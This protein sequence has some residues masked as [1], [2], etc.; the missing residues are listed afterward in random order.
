[1][2]QRMFSPK[3]PSC[4]SDIL[5]FW[6]EATAAKLGHWRPFNAADGRIDVDHL[7]V[8]QVKNEQRM[9]ESKTLVAV[10]LER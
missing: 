1:M 6:A 4:L 8:L 10:R 7:E 2:L 3:N 5:V 9:V